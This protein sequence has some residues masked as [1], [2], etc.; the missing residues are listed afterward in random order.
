[1]EL[2]LNISPGAGLICCTKDKDRIRNIHSVNHRM[3][4]FSQGLN[5]PFS[6]CPPKSYLKTNY[7][8]KPSFATLQRKSRHRALWSFQTSWSLF[9]PYSLLPDFRSWIQVLY[10]SQSARVE[11]KK[12]ILYC[13][14]WFV[15]LIFLVLKI[16]LGKVKVNTV[17]RGDDT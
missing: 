12:F 7:S 17:L 3:K 14:G 11:V 8:R 9:S 10:V 2:F 1:M 5:Q 16:F 15:K 13:S 4:D 6:N